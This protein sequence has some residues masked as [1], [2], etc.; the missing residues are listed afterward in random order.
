MHLVLVIAFI[1]ISVFLIGI[2]LIQPSKTDGLNFMSGGIA[3]TF[4]SKNKSRTHEVMQKK[5]TVVLTVL[6]VGLVIA[7]NLGL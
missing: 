2:V 6:F 7:L 1:V 4:Y 5:A 3:D